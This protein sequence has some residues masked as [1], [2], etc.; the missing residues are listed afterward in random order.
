MDDG[1][2]TTRELYEAIERIDTKLDQMITKTHEH[3]LRCE[4]RFSTLETRQ[5]LMWMV[6]SGAIVA[7][8]V[9]VVNTVV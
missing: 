5:N 8:A 4:N 6:F 9:A 1:P 7:L 2:V 3:R